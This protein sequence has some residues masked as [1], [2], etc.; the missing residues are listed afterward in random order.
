MPRLRSYWN[1]KAN[2]MMT[3]EQRNATAERY[4]LWQHDRDLNNKAKWNAASVERA[5]QWVLDHPEEAKERSRKAREARKAR[6][7]ADPEYA[8]KIRAYRR[9]LKRTPKGKAS[10]KWG[11]L[12]RKGWSQER[13]AQSLETQGNS[14]AICKS[15]FLS[16]P[17]ADHAHVEPPIPRGLLCSFCNSGLGFFKDRPELLDAAAEYL[18][19]VW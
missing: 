6:R 5:R 2:A 11:A 3:P 8:E 9:G 17:H 14:C 12:Q 4:A 16:V 18:R 1:G 19:R 13:Y 10:K 7:M 15:D